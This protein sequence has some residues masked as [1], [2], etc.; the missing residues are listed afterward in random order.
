MIA[1]TYINKSL[2]KLEW[3]L[4]HLRNSKEKQKY[5]SVH[6]KQKRP[7]WTLGYFSPLLQPKKNRWRIAEERVWVQ[8]LSS[9]TWTWMRSPW[10]THSIV[11]TWTLFTTFTLYLQPPKILVLRNWSNLWHKKY[12]ICARFNHTD[13]VRLFWN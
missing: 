6:L 7:L 1:S 11:K 3:T 9:P 5:L 8:K 4:W 13:W 10:D 2:I 12:S